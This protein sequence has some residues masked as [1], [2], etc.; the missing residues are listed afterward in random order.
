[1]ILTG[2]ILTITMAGVLGLHKKQETPVRR[3][4]M[5]SQNLEP[6]GTLGNNFSKSFILEIRKLRPRKLSEFS[7]VPSSSLE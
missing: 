2:Q 3:D 5:E 1:M 6:T 4:R 7:K